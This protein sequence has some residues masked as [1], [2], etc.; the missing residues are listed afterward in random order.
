MSH[1]ERSEAIP[2]DQ[3]GLPRP[4]QIFGG[5]AMTP[6]NNMK[7]FRWIVTLSYAGFIFYLSS[8]T[9]S[10][11]PMFPFSD[12]VFH[13]VLYFGLGGLT[14]WALRMTRLN[15]KISIFYIA[16]ICVALYGLSDE[17]HQLFVAGREFSLLDLLADAI[18]AAIG[19]T[20]AANIARIRHCE[21]LKGAKQSQ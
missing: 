18:G 6:K 19:I 1:C 8:R 16:F 5:L 9:W 17:V 14:L 13:L 7:I 21:R 10:G 20:V 2:R 4:P 12:K 15:G 11:V 3:I